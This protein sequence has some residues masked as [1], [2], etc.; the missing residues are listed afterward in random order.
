MRFGT[1]VAGVC[2]TVLVTG[3]FLIGS[4]FLVGRTFEAARDESTTLMSSMREQMFADMMHDTMR[5]VVYRALYAA[6]I[7]DAA[8]AAETSAEI[9]EYGDNFMAATEAQNALTLPADMRAA[10]DGVAE[11]LQGYLASAGAII[12]Q[13]ASGQADAATAA[14]PAFEE[15]FSILAGAMEGVS[16]TI[17]A[18]NLRNNAQSATAA[19]MSRA[20]SL[21]G[22]AAIL[23]LAGAMLLLSRRFI[24]KPMAAMN[25]S[26]QGLAEGQLDVAVPEQQP[27][28]EM[29]EMA[30]TLGVFRDAL[31]N[32][33][34]WRPMPMSRPNGRRGASNSRPSSTGA[35]P[36]W[37]VRR[38]QATSRDVSIRALMTA[39]CAKSPARSTISS[40]SSI[41]A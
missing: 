10:L 22:L 40:A 36:P 1:I 6:A 18:G 4:S 14:L 37:W 15:S 8:M 39:S 29:A 33:A 34:N 21:V 28:N 25:S 27:V 30:S 24:V 23:V 26:M 20:A 31:R 11:P 19:M 7:G 32:R 35:S 3:S 41:M 2:Y 38:L 12:E 9:V 5:G 16:D 13:A 17:E